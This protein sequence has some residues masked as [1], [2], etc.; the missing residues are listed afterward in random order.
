QTMPVVYSP[1]ALNCSGPRSSRRVLSPSNDHSSSANAAGIWTSS[2]PIAT[3]A[4]HPAALPLQI[5]SLRDR[6]A[7]RQLLEND[8][9]LHLRRARPVVFSAERPALLDRSAGRL[10]W[11]SGLGDGRP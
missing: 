10:C 8:V 11:V 5:A 6:I 2:A 3:P 1:S 9:L 7:T 4:N